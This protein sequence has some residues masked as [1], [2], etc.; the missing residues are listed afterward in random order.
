MRWYS[1]LPNINQIDAFSLL[2]ASLDMTRARHQYFRWT[3]RTAWINFA[4]VIVVPS[5]FGYMGYVTDVS[6]RFHSM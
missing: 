3:P 2:I 1:E 6:D 4:Y 5:I